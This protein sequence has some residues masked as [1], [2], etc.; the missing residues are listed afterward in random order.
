MKLNLKFDYDPGRR[1][2]IV[3]GS[4]FDQIRNIFSVENDAAK[5][6]RHYGR[7]I[8]KRK[9]VITPT[10]RFEPCLFYEIRKYLKNNKIDIKLPM[11]RS[12]HYR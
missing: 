6:A 3:S 4:Y 5:F 1:V 9:Y 12:Y 11:L 8:A 2:G 7:F 10:G